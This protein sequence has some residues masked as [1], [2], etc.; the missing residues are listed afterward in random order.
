MKSTFCDNRTPDGFICNHPLSQC[1]PEDDDGVPTLDCKVCQLRDHVVEM[2]QR[3]IERT[4][5]LM[6]RINELEEENKYLR[7]VLEGLQK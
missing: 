2:N 7:F 4:D 5:A 6:K 1:G 3:I